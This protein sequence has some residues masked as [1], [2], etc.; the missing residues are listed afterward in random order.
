[1]NLC[2]NEVKKIRELKNIATNGGDQTAAGSGIINSG[3]LVKQL[4][5]HTA[6]AKYKISKVCYLILFAYMY[7]IYI[8]TLYISI[9]IYSLAT[10]SSLTLI[11]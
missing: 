1:M 8:H 7:D 11:W 4:K 5:F 3:N 10:L 6:I 9:G 2:T